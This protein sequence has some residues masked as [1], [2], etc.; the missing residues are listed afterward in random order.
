M[1]PSSN[2]STKVLDL[3]CISDPSIPGSANSYQKVPKSTKFAEFWG[4]FGGKIWGS[5]RISSGKTAEK[6]L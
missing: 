3:L 1:V 2:R 5:S 4:Q 6:N